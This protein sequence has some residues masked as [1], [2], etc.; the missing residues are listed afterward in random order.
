MKIII[1]D[2]AAEASAAA[3]EILLQQIGAKPDSVLGL[4]TGGTPLAVYACLWID[5]DVQPG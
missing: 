2:T 4:P 3:T 1:K 5:H